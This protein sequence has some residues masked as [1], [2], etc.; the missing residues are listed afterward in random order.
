MCKLKACVAHNLWLWIKFYWN[1]ATPIC[2]HIVYGG[3]PA[4]VAKLS[5]CDDCV[6]G[7]LEKKFAHSLNIQSWLTGRALK[8]RQCFKLFR[9][10]M[11]E[12]LLCSP[13]HRRGDWGWE[14]TSPRLQ[15]GWASSD[16]DKAQPNPVIPC[17]L[18][19]P[20]FPF[21]NCDCKLWERVAF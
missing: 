13:F 2:L 11:S 5:S 19:N 16:W 4:T 18:C 12:I 1:P 9:W 17:S 21:W 7:S 8:G 15:V 20:S 14:V 3:I 6:A 10:T